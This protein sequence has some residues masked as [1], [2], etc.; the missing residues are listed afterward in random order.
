M[1]PLAVLA[2]LAAV[3]PAVAS[4]D[5][6]PPWR[7]PEGYMLWS[8]G[9]GLPASIVPEAFARGLVDGPHPVLTCESRSAGVQALGDDGRA[10]GQVQVRLDVHGAGM[11]AMGLDPEWE[12]HRMWYAGNVIWAQQGGWRHWLTCA[13]RAGLLP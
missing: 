10:F 13:T 7:P 3:L 12:P 11:R 2:I 4:A 1:K 8:N 5:G 9:P 6:A